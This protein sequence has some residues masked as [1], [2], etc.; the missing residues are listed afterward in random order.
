[1]GGNF[2]FQRAIK[3]KDQRNARRLMPAAV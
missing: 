2:G 3:R 1:M